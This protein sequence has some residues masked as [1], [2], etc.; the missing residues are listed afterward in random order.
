[1][2]ICETNIVE[3]DIVEINLSPVS[4][5]PKLNL[6]S[7]RPRKFM[8]KAS[9]LLLLLAQ[10]ILCDFSIDVTKDSHRDFD[11]VKLYEMTA[12]LNE[13]RA[14]FGLANLASIDLLNQM[15]TS[16]TGKIQVGS[17]AQTFEVVFDTGSSNLWI[18]SKEC[19]SA[20]CQ[21]KSQYD[22]KG[23]S[24]FFPDGAKFGIQYGTGSVEGHMSTDNVE[25]GGITAKDVRFGEATVMADFF[26]NQSHMDGILG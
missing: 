19:T 2:G 21:S 5:I 4:N 9:L 12:R 13:L 7:N 18:P 1:M 15:T 6:D 3:I 16:Y 26:K 10:A 8:L 14:K 22:S 11:K 24:S 20:T 25:M 23:S 17:P